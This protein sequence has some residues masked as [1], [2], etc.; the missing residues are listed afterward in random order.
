MLTLALYASISVNFEKLM[1]IDYQLAE[2]W[3]QP[4]ARVLD[5]GCGDG[6]MLAYLTQNWIFLAMAL[7]WPR[8]SMTVSP[9][10]STRR[11]ARPKR[12]LITLCRSKLWHCGHGSR[13]A[14]GG[15]TWPIIARYVTC[16]TWSNCY[17]PK[18]SPIGK[19]ASILA[20]KAWCRCQKPYLM[21]GITRPIFI[22]VL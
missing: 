12:W 21:R 16:G 17:L 22:Y 8:K 6:S 18:L 20:S 2:Q 3:I 15:C 19:T 13:V 1:K 11:R 10:V 4:N 5:L 9:K 14:S 7:N